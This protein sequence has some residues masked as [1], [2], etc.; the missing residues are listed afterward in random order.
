MWILFVVDTSASMN[1]RLSTGLSLLDAAKAAVEHFVKIR[2][3]DPNTRS[4]RYFLVT[5]EEGISAIK[6]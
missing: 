6:A 4:D 1:Q 5:C 3:R 2:G